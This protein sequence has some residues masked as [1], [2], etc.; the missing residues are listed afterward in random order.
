MVDDCVPVDL[1]ASRDLAALLARIKLGDAALA[2]AL[3]DEADRIVANL[4]CDC[5]ARRDIA[6]ESA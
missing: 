6:G 4:E 1:G 2:A 5:A 3:L